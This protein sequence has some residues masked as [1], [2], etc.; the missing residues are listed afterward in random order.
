MFKLPPTGLKDIDAQHE[1]LIECMKDLSLSITEKRA[2]SK[3]RETVDAL[4]N[5]VDNHFAYE[6][7]GMTLYGY[8][9]YRAHRKQHASFILKLHEISDKIEAGDG[10]LATETLIFLRDWLLE[11]IGKE[12]KFYADFLIKQVSAYP[13]RTQG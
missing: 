1:M 13:Y 9:Q 5:Y 12:D 7:R 3:T 10:L 11:H 8:P 2:A 4:F 6:E